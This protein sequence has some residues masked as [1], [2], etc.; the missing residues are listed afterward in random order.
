MFGFNPYCDHLGVPESGRSAL[1]QMADALVGT[2]NLIAIYIPEGTEDVYEAGAKRGRIVGAVR[3]LEMPEGSAIED[4]YYDDVV[5]GSRRWPFG[6][7]CQPVFAPAIS[8]CPPLREYVEHFFGSGSF[9]GYV[10]R[11]QRGPFEL[12]AKVGQAINDDFDEFD[13]LRSAKAEGQRRT[14]G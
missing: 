6:W 12:D 1:I 11:F 13:V 10:S 9:S 4:Y 3:L 8:D 7:P 2:S 5:D 14:K